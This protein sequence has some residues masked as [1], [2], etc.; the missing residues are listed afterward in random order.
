MKFGRKT[1]K[2]LPENDKKRTEKK[3]SLKE[4][5]KKSFNGKY[6]KNGSYSVAV[7][8]VFVVIIVVINLIVNTLPTKYSEIDVSDQKIF[9]IGSQTEEFLKNLDKDVTIYQVAE[10]GSEDET[11]KKLLEKYEEASDHI[12]VVQKDPVV[13]PKFTSEYTDQQLTSNSLII[14][15]G[16]RNKIVDYSNIYETSMDYST[17]SYNTTGFDGEGQITSAISYV[18]SE[19]LPVLYTLDGHGEKE[20]DSVIQEDIEKANVEIKSLNLLTEESVPEDAACLMINSPSSDISSDEKDAIIAYLEGGGKA[21]IFSDY[22]EE[23][24][25]NFDAVLENYGVERVDG[26]VLEGDPQHYAMQMNYYLLPTVGS[27]EPVSDFSTQGYYVLAPYAQGIRKL[28][29]VRDTVTVESLLTTSDSAYSKVDLNSEILEKADEDVEG[30][31]DIG[32]S[33]TETLED[34]KETQIIYYSTANLMDSQ[35]NQ[36]VAG[37]NEQ[38]IM[39]SLNWMLSSEETETISIP[40]KSLEISSLTLTAYDVSFWKICVMGLIPGVFLVIGFGVWLKRR[41]A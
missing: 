28:D 24:M 26:I 20:L 16:E 3:Q 33:I 34:D 4:K 13:N 40:S 17:Y 32:V 35:I 31:F 37:G 10:S 39:E 1:E 30:P 9:S 6:I 2:N 15:C 25:E 14:E 18:T 19:D 27:A 8:V 7:S 12:K 23:S 41:K 22:T 38:M 11:V 5:I 36:V 21:M 29:S